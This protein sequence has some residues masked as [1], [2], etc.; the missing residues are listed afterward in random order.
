MVASYYVQTK[1][2]TLI[3]H[4]IRLR[5]KIQLLNSTFQTQLQTQVRRSAYI[6]K[7]ILQMETDQD[8]QMNAVSY[9]YSH[10]TQGKKYLPMRRTHGISGICSLTNTILLTNLKMLACKLASYRRNGTKMIIH[11]LQ[12]LMILQNTHIKRQLNS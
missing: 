3:H 7:S 6:Q 11:N 8:M 9:L 12:I 1:N 2:V 5:R 10:L 4:V